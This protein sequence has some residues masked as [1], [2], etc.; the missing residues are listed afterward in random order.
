MEKSLSPAFTKE[1][2]RRR[3]F[4][5]MEAKARKQN[6]ATTQPIHSLAE[7]RMAV[8][9]GPGKNSGDVKLDSMVFIQIFGCVDAGGRRGIT[10]PLAFTLFSV[11]FISALTLHCL[12]VHEA[13]QLGF[14]RLITQIPEVIDLCD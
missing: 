8:V 7:P 12:V 13:C 14:R 10:I 4:R 3:A 1:R 2:W 6:A 5:C 11:A 9:S